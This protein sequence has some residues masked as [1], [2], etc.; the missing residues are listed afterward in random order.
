MQSKKSINGVFR[1]VKDRFDQ[2][3][4][5]AQFIVD[6]EG[7][8][9]VFIYKGTPG[10]GR[11]TATAEIIAG[12]RVRV[13]GRRAKVETILKSPVTVA[14]VSQAMSEMEES[15]KMKHKAW[16]K[17]IPPGANLQGDVPSLPKKKSGQ[18]VR[19]GL[20]L[21]SDGTWI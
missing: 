20:V 18:V 3:G 19:Y 15:A 17:T 8:G 10:D 21:Q 6:D 1:R 12:N 16:K 5:Y 11:E 4:R 9:E 14:T 13:F 2:L 7:R